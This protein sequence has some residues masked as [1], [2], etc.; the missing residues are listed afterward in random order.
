MENI[1]KDL[2]WQG[3][4]PTREAI[5]QSI[6]AEANA[7][8]VYRAIKSKRI[9]NVT[10]K[11][12]QLLLDIEEL[13]LKLQGK[14]EELAK[15]EMYLNLRPKPLKVVDLI[16]NYKK[17][18]EHGHGG[19]VKIKAG[20]LKAFD[21]L[22]NMVARYDRGLLLTDVD[23][24]RMNAFQQHLVDRGVVNSSI[25][26]T[27]GKFRTVFRHYATLHGM[28]VGWMNQFN[29]VQDADGEANET[30]FLS[31]VELAELEA[32]DIPPANRAQRE[33]RR[34][35]LFGVET[36][37]RRSD[38]QVSQ[39]NVKGRELVVKTTKTGKVA[40]IPFTDKA[41]ALF[42][43]GPFRLFIEAQFNQALRAMCKRLPSMQH[44][45]TVYTPVG[46]ETKE[47]VF[48]KWELMTSHVA[49]KT[50]AH[51]ALSRGASTTAVAEWLAHKSTAMLDKHYTNKKALARQEAHKVLSTPTKRKRAAKTAA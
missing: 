42:A 6:Q 41:R 13:E 30:L 26:E 4:T 8:G 38:Y 31:A 19:T 14:R 33:V 47:D 21:V 40:R 17:L 46:S 24:S 50:Y 37:L 45:V 43:V 22:A 48:S 1:E 32:L 51:N 15:A 18:K 2:S 39:D 5:N 29:Y 28:E 7:L 3:I 10:D 35:F 12:A 49:R 44:G 27:L 23:L 34:Q 11:R 9:A 25:R 20:S 36:G 16:G